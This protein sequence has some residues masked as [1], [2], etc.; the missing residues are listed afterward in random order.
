[1]GDP[2]GLQQLLGA[3]EEKKKDN[4]GSDSGRHWMAHA[5]GT[6][7]NSTPP[8]KKHHQTPPHPPPCASLPFARNRFKNGVSKELTTPTKTWGH[9]RERGG[10]E[11][12]KQQP[13]IDPPSGF[14]GGGSA[15]HRSCGSAVRPR[16]RADSMGRS[17]ADRLFKK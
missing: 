8:Q 4:G 5:Y 2:Y 3:C 14:G 13:N 6:A 17:S 12:K 7:Y 11:K 1:M 9:C 15:V 10:L 16:G